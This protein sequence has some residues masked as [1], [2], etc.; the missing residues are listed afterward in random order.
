MLI[1]VT[2]D[3]HVDFWQG[4]AN[5]VDWKSLKNPGSNVIIIDGDTSNYHD[6][7]VET[8][9]RARE[10]YE[11]VLVL[12]GNHEHYESTIVQGMTVYESMRKLEREL[13]EVGA[14]FLDGH[15]TLLLDDVLF[16]GANGWYDFA[17][18][19]HEYTAQQSFTKWL[20]VK[21]SD[22]MWKGGNNDAN[23]N[24]GLGGPVA[25]ARAD[26]NALTN[27][28]IEAQNDDRV[29]H[30]VVV[31]HTLSKDHILAWDRRDATNGHYGNSLMRA[32]RD[33]DT[34]N[35]IKVMINGHTH[36]PIDQIQHGIRYVCSPRGYE[37]ACRNDDF[38][39][40]QIDVCEQGYA[41][42]FGEI[43]R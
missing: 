41:S 3:L 13:T 25:Y 27:R 26:A 4:H 5:S 7:V 1:D 2:S 18:G 10:Y 9:K 23:L 42:A 6:L 37:F 11:F 31:T 24:F 39:L 38:H 12:D 17:F 32:V 28:V 40:L 29:N 33:A 20:G 8:V 43:E 34:K 36:N 35:K 21:G 30:I 15:R 16:I 22:G 14:I 19:A